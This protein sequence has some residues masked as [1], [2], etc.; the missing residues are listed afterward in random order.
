M[1]AQRK[2]R[3]KKLERPKTDDGP[4]VCIVTS[5]INM[6]REEALRRIG[7]EPRPQDFVFHMA[8]LPEGE[9]PY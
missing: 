9:E 8:I 6:S 3:L 4:K 2:R 1:T 7:Y 5:P